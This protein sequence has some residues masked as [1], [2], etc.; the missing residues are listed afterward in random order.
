MQSKGRYV[1]ML[2]MGGPPCL[3]G[4]AL[5]DGLS[6]YNET[7]SNDKIWKGKFRGVP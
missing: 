6:I 5:S 3:P 4:K 7:T 1:C 2:H